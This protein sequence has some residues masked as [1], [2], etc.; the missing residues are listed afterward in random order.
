M[1]LHRTSRQ[2]S[3]SAVFRNFRFANGHEIR[4]IFFINYKISVEVNVLRY[5]TVSHFLIVLVWRRFGVLCF[6]FVSL[7]SYSCSLSSSSC[8]RISH[9]CSLISH[10]CSLIFPIRVLSFPS[11]IL[12]FPI[13]VHLFPVHV[14][15]VFT[16]VPFV[17]HRAYSCSIRVQFV[18]SISHSCSL[19][20]HSCSHLCGVLDMIQI[21][22]PFSVNQQNFEGGANF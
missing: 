13:H 6:Q 12:S 10:L 11:H 16:R 22:T 19:V 17:F 2:N 18:F 20:F 15:L 9:S 1:S 7:I 3:L 21:L 14:L 8:S 4:Y 5:N